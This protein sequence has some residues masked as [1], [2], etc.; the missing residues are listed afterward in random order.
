MIKLLDRYS[1]YNEFLRQA[2]ALMSIS[3]C[4]GMYCGLLSLQANSKAGQCLELIFD[5][6]FDKANLAQAECIKVLREI[7]QQ[8]RIDL[9]DDGIEFYLLM[10]DDN[11][12]ISIRASDLQFWTQGYIFGLGLAGLDI[13]RSLAETAENGDSEESAASEISEMIKDIIGISQLSIDGLI[14]S[15][16]NEKDLCELIE[17]VRVGVLYIQEECNP[18]QKSSGLH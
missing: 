5:D 4:H 17:Y 13:E 10:A 15:D 14:E 3:E 18:V 2:N 9:N 7:F 11:E 1:E 6:E 16:D 12:D 8:T